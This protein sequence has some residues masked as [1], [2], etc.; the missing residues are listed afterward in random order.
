MIS[1]LK[2]NKSETNI[3][4][5]LLSYSKTSASSMTE[6]FSGPH[7]KIGNQTNKAGSRSIMIDSP[8]PHKLGQPSAFVNQSLSEEQKSALA[9]NAA[10]SNNF[11]DRRMCKDVGLSES[12]SESSCCSLDQSTIS[13]RKTTYRSGMFDLAGGLRV[14]EAWVTEEKEPSES[15]FQHQESILPTTTG[16]KTT[17]SDH[18]LLKNQIEED[19]DTENMD[20]PHSWSTVNP[21]SSSLRSEDSD[22]I[23]DLRNDVMCDPP[24]SSSYNSTKEE[25]PKDTINRTL[26]V[27]NQ[28]S[29]VMRCRKS[30]PDSA[31]PY[32]SFRSKADIMIPTVGGQRLTTNF[33]LSK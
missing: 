30:K 3:L 29:S 21:F 31:C 22:L 27:S 6:S 7:K 8:V 28:E 13:N 14:I 5:K 20:S 15:D 10:P 18:L 19:I 23:D 1:E 11:A 25:S 16:S 33:D 12:D 4:T 24:P 26:F 32:T 17:R 9:F 2:S